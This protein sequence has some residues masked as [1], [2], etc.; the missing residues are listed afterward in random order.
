MRMFNGTSENG[1]ATPAETV[2]VTTLSGITL[3]GQAR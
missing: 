2:D 1:V 3:P